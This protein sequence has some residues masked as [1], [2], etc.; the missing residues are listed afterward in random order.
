MR[1]K[2]IA[3]VIASLVT[4]AVILL[5]IGANP[6]SNAVT[7]RDLSF[8]SPASEALPAHS[9]D[10]KTEPF[11]GI[12]RESLLPAQSE[13]AEDVRTMAL[14]GALKE[15]ELENVERAWTGYFKGTNRAM[16]FV[17]RRPSLEQYERM[18]AE[19]QRSLDGLTDRSFKLRQLHTKLLLQYVSFPKP[20]R[21]VYMMLEP[22]GKTAF[23]HICHVD[24]LEESYRDDGDPPHVGPSQS[25]VGPTDASNVLFERYSHIL[26]DEE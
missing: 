15:I 24:T 25:S 11:H 3:A 10:G 19:V 26:R 23:L 4:G 22:D 7:H 9:E 6:P 13:R 20:L 21:S 12:V 17:I 1:K 5:W 16:V 8:A 14:K 2:I 18:S